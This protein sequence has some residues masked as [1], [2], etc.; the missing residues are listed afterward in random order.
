M[1]SLGAATDHS[2][3]STCLSEPAP[4][5]ESEA[6]PETFSHAA[7]EPRLG[8]V[9]LEEATPHSLHLSWTA[10]EGEFD[11]FEVQ[12]TD[13]DGQRQE[14]NVGGDQHDITISDLESDHRYLVSLYG[15]HDGQRVGPAHIE[16]M[17]GEQKNSAHSSFQGAMRAHRR[18]ESP[19]TLCPSLRSFSLHVC[20]QPQERRMMNLQNLPLSPKPRPPCPPSL[21]SSPAWGS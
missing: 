7:S 13:E 19:R 3:L 2:P 18:A 6:E 12:Y 11:S 1:E 20:V 9:T 5:E 8:E 14:V 10:A 17:T 4:R 15:F 21:P 16:A